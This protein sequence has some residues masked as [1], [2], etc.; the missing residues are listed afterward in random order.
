MGKSMI[1]YVIVSVTE[2][3]IMDVYEHNAPVK[4]VDD[5]PEFES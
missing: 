2:S 5:K 1:D 3:S 4:N